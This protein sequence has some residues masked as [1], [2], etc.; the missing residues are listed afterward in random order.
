M[1]HLKSRRWPVKRESKNGRK[2]CCCPEIY[3]PGEPASQWSGLLTA[4]FPRPVHGHLHA[5]GVDRH[6]PRATRT[7]AGSKSSNTIV[8]PSL[9]RYIYGVIKSGQISQRY[10]KK[11]MKHILQRVAHT[12]PTNLAATC[13]FPLS[14][15]LSAIV[16]LKLL[17]RPL[18]PMNRR[19]L[20]LATLLFMTCTRP[21]CRLPP[22]F[23]PPLCCSSAPRR[24]S[25]RCRP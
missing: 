16:R 20:N 6:H 24:S 9:S 21:A 17:P 2:C 4:G 5:L 10:K 23:L 11:K 1:L 7:T 13:M 15:Y 12:S 8:L 3:G 14:L 25:R 19:S 18:R 22:S